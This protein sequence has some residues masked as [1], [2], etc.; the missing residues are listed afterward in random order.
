MV[1]AARDADFL[2]FVTPH[3]FVS[4][5]CSKLKG[6]IKTSAVAVSLI[7]VSE[8]HVYI[9]VKKIFFCYYP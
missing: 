5:I 1:D 3:Q 6:N 4:G 2:V 8:V 9:L 7:K